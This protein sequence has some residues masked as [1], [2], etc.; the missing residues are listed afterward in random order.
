MKIKQQTNLT[1]TFSRPLHSGQ[2][3]E[4]IQRD[5]VSQQVGAS[6]QGKSSSSQSLELLEYCLKI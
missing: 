5:D 1:G 6:G 2:D 4:N 3:R